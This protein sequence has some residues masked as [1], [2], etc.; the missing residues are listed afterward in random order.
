MTV[1]GEQLKLE[2][3]TATLAAATVG[4][5]DHPRRIA[6][7]LYQL[8]NSG[9]A[10]SADH[11]RDRLPHD[12]REWMDEHPNVL[13]AQFGMHRRAGVIQHI[14]WCSPARRTRHGNPNR[15]W[16]GAHAA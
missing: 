12:T 14:G 9:E 5:H 2:G 10:F 13:P 7:V 4:Y 3:M 6:E 8:I 1:T 11:V 15:I 16:I